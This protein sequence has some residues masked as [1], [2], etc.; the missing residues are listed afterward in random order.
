[1]ICNTFTA[2]LTVYCIHCT[3]CFPQIDNLGMARV[4]QYSVEKEAWSVKKSHKL[5][6]KGPLTA[7]VLI[8]N[9]QCVV[10]CEREKDNE[11]R[12]SIKQQK[13]YGSEGLLEA[14]L[15]RI[16]LTVCS[17]TIFG[18]CKYVHTRMQCGVLVPFSYTAVPSVCE[19]MYEMSE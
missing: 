15:M 12:C 11:Q 19:Y 7:A 16:N 17:V 10:W 4:W 9:Q 5:K 13:L 2:L 1:M 3:Y 14:G 6:T 18:S 8:P